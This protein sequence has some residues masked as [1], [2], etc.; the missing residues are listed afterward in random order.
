VVAIA[1]AIRGTLAVLLA[2]AIARPVVAQVVRGDV[3]DERSGAPVFGALVVAYDSSGAR[4]A[5]TISDDS[6]RFAM[7]IRAPGRYHLGIERIGYATGGK[8]PFEIGPGAT[9]Q[10]HLVASSVAVVLPRIAVKGN[11]RCVVNPAGGAETAAL[12]EEARKALYASE[13]A[14][15]QRNVLVVRRRYRRRLDSSG[16]GGRGLESQDTVISDRSFEPLRTPDELARDGYRIGDTT[17][18][19]PQ[20]DNLLSDVFASTHCFE[21]RR[22]PD[23]HRGLVGLSFEP[24]LKRSV[25]DVTGVIW[26]DSASAE[27]RYMEFRHTNSFPEVSPRKYGGR[28]EFERL[29]NGIWIVSRWFLRLPMHGNATTDAA[30]GGDARFLGGGRTAPGFN[31]EGGEVLSASVVFTP[32]P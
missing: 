9:V 22:D 8:I 30:G 28:L 25:T 29:P 21:V 31:E 10:A 12:W 23:K 27:L 13:L 1:R 26:L 7:R 5:G 11:S 19:A 6:G 14:I 4:V 17:F 15:E 32:P 2:T 18:V 24:A 20:A 16:G 3:A